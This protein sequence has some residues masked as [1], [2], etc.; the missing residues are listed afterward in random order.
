MMTVPEPLCVDRLYRSCDPDELDFDTTDQADALKD[1]F[2]QDRAVEALR[3][4]AGM[5]SHGHNLFVLGPN[6]I[7]KHTVTRHFLEGRARGE[8]V[9]P[10]RCYLYNFD[11]PNAPRLLTLAPGEGRRFATDLEQLCDE[12]RSAIPAIFESEEY[13]SRLQELQRSFGRRQE[14]AI[15]EI[16]EEAEQ[17]DIALIMTQSG[18]TFAPRKDGETLDQDEFQKL[19]K[20]EREGIERT[21]EEL[22]GKL[23][24]A[25]Q[26]FPKWRKESQEEVR[27][28]NEEMAQ[29]AVGQSIDDLRERYGD[30]DMA[31]AHLDGVRRDVVDNVDALRQAS[32]QEGQAEPILQ[33]YRVNVIVDH[34]D[35]PGAPVVYE[36][37]PSYHHLVGRIEHR[38][39]QGALLTDFSLIKAGALQRANGGYLMLDALKLLAQPFAWEALKRALYARELKLESLEQMYSMMSTV[40]LTPEPVPLDLKVVLLGD[41]MLYYLLSVLD[42]DF[43]ELFKVE[44]DFEDDVARDVQSQ[45]LYGQLVATL[46]RRDGLR[47]LDRGGVARVIEHASRLADDSERMTMHAR[48]L[49]DLLREADHFAGE[50]GADTVTAEH[51]Q[52]AID[53]QERRA[54]RVRE[55]LERA[56]QRDTIHI[57]TEGAATGQVN[58]LAVMQLGGYAFGKGSRITA[59]VRLGQGQL[60]D[61]EREAK[62]GGNIHSKAMMIIGNYVGA[63]YA[64]ERPLSLHASLA[65]EQNYGGVEGDSASVAEVCALLS[66]LADVPLTQGWAVTGSIDQHGRVQAVGGVN[67]KIEGFFETCERRGL[68]GG[69][70]ILLPRA[71]VPHLMLRRSVREAVAAERF[72]IIPL[73]HVDQALEVLTGMPAG[74]RGDDGGFPEGTFNRRVDERVDAFAEL[75]RRLGRDGGDDAGGAPG[76]N[77]DGERV[78]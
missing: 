78:D 23:Q 40:S 13:Q 20:E 35:A 52:V 53:A 41:R 51:V 19:P 15:R 16:R 11:D 5:R 60:L 64:A 39:M 47:A 66:A 22:Q 33:R 27:K 37:L 49:A 30:N 3:F 7:G 45:R 50:G 6:G 55:R 25:L 38:V 18:F 68:T 67:E 4:G 26:Q 44:A 31:V 29:V 59:T 69:Q 71:N 54:S 8:A 2:G 21:V 10:D 24:K 48:S 72:R 46:A 17:H 43:A 42:P 36:D 34:G 32:S 76:T 61:I 65:F 62:L 63:R 1:V 74:E 56:I 28:L 75:R 9:P 14:Q 57:E 12:L 58:G 73:D 70:G 77:D